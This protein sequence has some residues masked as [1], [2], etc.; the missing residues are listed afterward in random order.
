MLDSPL[1]SSLGKIGV[2]VNLSFAVCRRTAKSS[3]P[4]D[5]TK[6]HGKAH[7]HGKE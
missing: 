4:C 3:L 1:A 5:H 6:T 7:A 2:A